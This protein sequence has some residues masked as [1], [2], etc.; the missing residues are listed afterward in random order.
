MQRTQIYLT[1]EQRRRIARRAADAG[2]SQAEVIRRILDEVLG[3]EGG[4][5]ERRA[6]VLATAGILADAPDWPEWLQRVRGRGAD[7]RL[8]E[9]G[10]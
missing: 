10:L 7:G 2:V 9:L 5:D 6:A 3:I 4:K 8:R 1:D